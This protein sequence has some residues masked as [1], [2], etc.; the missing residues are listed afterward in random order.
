MALHYDAL[1]LIE[2]HIKGRVLSLGYPDLCIDNDEAQAVFGVKPRRWTDRNR[3]HKIEHPLPETEHLF[4]A[5]CE[6]VCVDIVK[7]AGCE[8]IRDLNY[9]QAMGEFD[10]VI[11]PGTTEHCFNIGQA[12]LNAA[13][14]VKA[15]GRV[16]H[17][18]PVTM[19]NHGFYNPCPTLWHDFYDQN[20][21]EIE[22]FT[23]RH[24]D[25][26]PF[27]VRRHWASRSTLPSEVGICFM[28]KRLAVKPLAYP[29]QT[30]YRHLL[31]KAA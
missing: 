10:L 6:F 30:K 21:W 19:V 4:K 26:L 11:D 28:A 2:P 24:K 7:L 12:I 13:G 25:T 22:H 17:L 31:E 14:A 16:L 1:K 9:P 15:G 23:L 29:V 18:S 3:V 27:D 8:E 5:R 20:G